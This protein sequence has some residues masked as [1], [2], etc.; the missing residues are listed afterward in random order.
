M[1]QTK[2]KAPD[3]IIIVAVA[4]QPHTHPNYARHLRQVEVLGE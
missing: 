2:I 4:W 3:Y 1:G